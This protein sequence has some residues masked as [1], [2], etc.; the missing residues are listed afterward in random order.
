MSMPSD[1]DVV[2]GDEEVGGIFFLQSQKLTVS[3]QAFSLEGQAF[4]V[5]QRDL[6]EK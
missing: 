5:R 6:I 3:L 2:A 1:V 4:E